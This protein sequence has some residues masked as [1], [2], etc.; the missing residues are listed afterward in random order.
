MWCHLVNVKHVKIFS[1]QNFLSKFLVTKSVFMEV[2]SGPNRTLHFHW[3]KQNAAWILTKWKFTLCGFVD[4]F[5]H[6]WHSFDIVVSFLTS[7]FHFWHVIF[8]SHFCRSWK[9]LWWQEWS[10]W[11]E[12]VVSWCGVNVLAGKFLSCGALLGSIM[13]GSGEEERLPRTRHY[14]STL[15]ADAVL[16]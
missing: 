12:V 14:I 11:I 4:D 2:M 15:V 16:M 13:A 5:W 9:N 3:C 7:W 8:V 1:S 10:K 6:V